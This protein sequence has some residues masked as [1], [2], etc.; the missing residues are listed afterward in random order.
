M[1]CA[2]LKSIFFPLSLSQ[3]HI[4]ER[5]KQAVRTMYGVQYNVQRWDV[6]YTNLTVLT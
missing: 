4:C 3:K 6:L 2:L 5:R 1:I